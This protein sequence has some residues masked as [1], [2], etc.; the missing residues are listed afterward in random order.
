MN[1]KCLDCG[2]GLI[3]FSGEKMIVERDGDSLP[4]S[5]LSGWRCEKCDYVEFDEKSAWRYA[6]AGDFL[7]LKSRGLI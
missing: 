7:I 4:V 5:D 2:E 3:P 1:L 6:K